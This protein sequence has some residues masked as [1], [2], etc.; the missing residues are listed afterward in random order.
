MEQKARGCNTGTFSSSAAR[1]IRPIQFAATL[2]G[3]AVDAARATVCRQRLRD[4]GLRCGRPPEEAMATSQAGALCGGGRRRRGIRRA[5]SG[6]SRFSTARENS[7]TPG[8]TKAAGARDGD[9]LHQGRRA[10]R[11]RR[12]PRHPALR[13]Q[14]QVPNNIGKDN[15][16]N[17]LL[18]PNGVVDFAVD[19]HDTIYAANP[20]KHRVE[21]YT[22]GGELL[23]HIGRFTA[24]IRRDSDRLLQSDQRGGPRPHLH[25]GKGR[26]ARQGL[27]F[28]WEAGRR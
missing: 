13:P 12:G 3:I 15:R 22:P 2:R 19:A 10:G 21:R 23:G 4:Q 6:R 20:G 18:I 24:S 26:P 7:S 17:G 16:V 25:H 5:N 9:R 11:R 28:Q 14:R 27:R 8:A 1:A